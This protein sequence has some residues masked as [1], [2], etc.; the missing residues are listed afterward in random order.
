MGKCQTGD[1]GFDWSSIRKSAMF[2]LVRANSVRYW[3]VKCA[4]RAPPTIASDRQC[5]PDALWET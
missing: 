5:V 4:M 1:S 3:R 2:F